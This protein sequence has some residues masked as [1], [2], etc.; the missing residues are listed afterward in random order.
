[1]PTCTAL[2]SRGGMCAP[3][4]PLRATG[5]GLV[6]LEGKSL[7]YDAS[8]P[9]LEGGVFGV[10]PRVKCGKRKFWHRRPQGKQAAR[11]EAKS[12]PW[13][14][15]GNVC[16][17]GMSPTLLP[18]SCTTAS[19][20]PHQ[21]TR[22]REKM[23]EVETRKAGRKEWWVRLASHLLHRRD[24]DLLRDVGHSAGKS[25]DMPTRPS[26]ILQ[27]CSSLTRSHRPFSLWCFSQEAMK[28]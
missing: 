11:S 21:M 12:S 18:R 26:T 6:D 16:A 15:L 3:E 4:M 22:S 25:W 5:S 8:K 19:S 28:S 17:C 1:M 13:F 2:A 20:V 24:S 23:D 14:S 7:Q 10:L 9:V 27:C